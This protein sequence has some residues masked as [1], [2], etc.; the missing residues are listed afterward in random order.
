MQTSK[1]KESSTS[2]GRLE[3]LYDLSEEELLEYELADE[4]FTLCE[5]EEEEWRQY[6]EEVQ[7]FKDLMLECC[8]DATSSSSKP[9]I[10]CESDLPESGLLDLLVPSQAECLEG[11]VDVLSFREAGC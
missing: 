7:Q 8:S 4:D 11:L 2:P 6:D 10:N 3:S 1:D 5:E 9:K